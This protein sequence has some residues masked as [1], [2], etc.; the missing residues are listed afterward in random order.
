MPDSKR[1]YGSL[2]NVGGILTGLTLAGYV[3][4]WVRFR[5]F[6]GAFG[7]P[8]TTSEA[9]VSAILSSGALPVVFLVVSLSVARYALDDLYDDDRAFLHL[10]VISVVAVALFGGAHLLS[11]AGAHTIAVQV[12]RATLLFVSFCLCAGIGY[13]TRELDAPAESV[14]KDL[15]AVSIALS[16]LYIICTGALGKIEGRKARDPGASALSR[17]AVADTSATYRLVHST[18]F[19]VYAADLRPDGEKPRV[20][21]LRA[22]D[23]EYISERSLDSLSAE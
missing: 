21:V 23:I 18:E 22:E 17:V 4:G 19:N 12:S 14:P 13:V 6:V 10:L 2:V 3:L 20:Q 11:S 9:P 1:L 7:A 15:L 8:W 5:N 16:L